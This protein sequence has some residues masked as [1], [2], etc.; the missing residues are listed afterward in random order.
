MKLPITD[1]QKIQSWLRSIGETDQAIIDD[2]IR[3][4]S[5]DREKLDYFVARFDYDGYWLLERDDRIDVIVDEQVVMSFNTGE[6]PDWESDVVMT[7][8]QEIS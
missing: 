4:C 7:I 2:I 8:P 6:K 1:R 3:Q 5:K